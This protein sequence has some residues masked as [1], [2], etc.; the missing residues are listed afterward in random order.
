MFAA[1]SG[2]AAQGEANPFFGTWT[3]SST[4]VGDH[5]ACKN[6]TVVYR[7]MPSKEHPGLVTLLADKII[8][9]K[10][11]PMVMLDFEYD[12]A[13]KSLAC[14]FMIG[15][16]HGIWAYEIATGD[17]M[18]GTL[19]VLPEKSLARVVKVHRARDED[20]PEAPAPQEYLP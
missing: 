7:F 5:P 11:V 6:E 15:H 9:G 4:C 1:G 8:A 20:L 2:G 10:R 13:A 19:V 18:D 17:E 14:E 12:A 16:T 3:G